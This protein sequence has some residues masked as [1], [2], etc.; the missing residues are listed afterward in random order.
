MK[1]DLE[2]GNV[3]CLNS[4]IYCLVLRVRKLHSRTEALLRWPNGTLRYFFY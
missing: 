1:H 3:I 4:T 2:V